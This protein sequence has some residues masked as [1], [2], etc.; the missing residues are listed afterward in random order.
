MPA[1]TPQGQISINPSAAPP[2]TTVLLTGSGLPP[3][4]TFGVLW[5]GSHVEDVPTDAAG[6][7]SANFQI[8]DNASGAFHLICLQEDAATVCANFTLQAQAPSR[9]TTAAAV[10]APS[11]SP[12]PSHSPSPPRLPRALW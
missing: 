7:M 6:G 3:N 8:P 11:P 1:A 10:V 4:R 9:V 2:A 5:D 12:G